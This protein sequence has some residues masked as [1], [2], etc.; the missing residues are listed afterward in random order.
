MDKTTLLKQLNT[1]TSQLVEKYKPEKNGQQ[2]LGYRLG[3]MENE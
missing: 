2:T 3:T 1:L